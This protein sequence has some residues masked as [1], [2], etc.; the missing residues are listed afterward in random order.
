MYLKFLLHS[1][2]LN[3]LPAL[4]IS[5]SPQAAAWRACILSLPS[6]IDPENIP[7]NTIEA[8]RS[9]WA[10]RE[11]RA[12]VRRGYEFKLD[13]QAVWYLKSL[14]RL[15]KPDYSPTDA[16]LMCCKPRLAGAVETSFSVGDLRYRMYDVSR[17]RGGRRKWFHCFEN[18]YVLVFCVSIADYDQ[19]IPF[20]DGP[21]SVLSAVGNLQS[22]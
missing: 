15:T 18:V 2:I 4:N 20:E 1:V 19:P 22:P 8:M 21:V 9:L 7:L 12:A 11:I 5:L 13:E 6:D 16:D 14:D 17:Q 10:N 3:A